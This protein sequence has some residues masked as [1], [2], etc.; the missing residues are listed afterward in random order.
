M[1][2]ASLPD[3]SPDVHLFDTEFGP[4]ALLADASQVFALDEE[5]R[6]ELLRAAGLGPGAVREA[7][8]LSRPLSTAMAAPRDPPLRS[9]SLA[10]AQACNLGCTYCYAQEGSFGGKA[11]EMAW[12]TAETAVRRLFADAERGDTLHISFLGGEPLAA[13]E[14]LRDAT[15]LAM[16]LVRAKGANAKFS[17]TTNG[18]LLRPDDGEFFE[19]HRF[20]VT[21]SLDGIGAVH[22]RQR[23]FKNGR[24]SYQRAIENV[25]PLLAMQRRM[26]ISARV[27]VTPDNLD[28]RETLDGFAELGFTSVGFSP[29]LRSPTGKSELAASDFEVLLAQMVACG[30]EFERRMAQ[31]KRYPFANMHSAMREIHRGTHRPYPCGAGAGYFGVSADG[32]MFACHRFVDDDAGAMGHVETGVD[33]ARQRQWLEER[34]VDRQEPCRSCWARYLCGGGCHHE[35]IARGRPACDFIRGWLEYCLQAYVRLSVLRPDYFSGAAAPD[36]RAA[37]DVAALP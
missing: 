22:D 4:H 19:R 6:E 23:P 9:L 37:V 15:E 27:T 10:V 26:Q 35:V 11:K 8:G 33:R 30:R 28:L 7:I 34:L 3:A 29:V 5:T 2:T 21:V 36:G 25:M 17:V 32:N 20:A 24:G 14:L 16:R 12:R 13:R 1:I 18:T 31:G